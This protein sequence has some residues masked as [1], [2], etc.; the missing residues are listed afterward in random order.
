MVNITPNVS[1]DQISAGMNQ[2][3]E[4]SFGASSPTY[5]IINNTTASVADGDTVIMPPSV[6]NLKTVN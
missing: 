5:N 6:H 2:L 3:H 1:P 4:G